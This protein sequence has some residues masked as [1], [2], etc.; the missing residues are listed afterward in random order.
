M[1]KLGESINELMAALAAG[2]DASR[3]AQRAAAVNVMRRRSL[4]LRSVYGF[5]RTSLFSKLILDRK[6]VV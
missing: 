6:S 3:K 2:D 4:P 1:R 5:T